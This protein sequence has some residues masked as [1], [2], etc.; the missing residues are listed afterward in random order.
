MKEV[1]KNCQQLKIELKNLIKIQTKALKGS[2]Y[3]RLKKENYNLHRA[4]GQEK[5]RHIK[6]TFCAQTSF[7]EKKRNK[8]HYH[9]QRAS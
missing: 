6:V 3:I 8:Y 2:K 9:L 5:T 1:K 4:N 7:G